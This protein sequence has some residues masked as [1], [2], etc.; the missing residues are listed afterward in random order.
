MIFLN[1][2]KASSMMKTCGLLSLDMISSEMG[3]VG[4]ISE[5]EGEEEE[6]E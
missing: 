5:E 4:S 3:V 1:E 2:T 6:E